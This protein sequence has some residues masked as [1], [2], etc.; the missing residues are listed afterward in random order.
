MKGFVPTPPAI[1]D[2]MV[3]K[4]FA[5]GPPSPNATLLDP[6]CG[7]GAFIE[8]VIR[9]CES[10]GLPLPKIT[11][12]DSNPDHIEVARKVFGGYPRI[13][14]REEDFLAVHSQQYDYIIGNPPY[15]PITSLSLAE[16][17]AYRRK[18]RTASGRFDLYLLFF[19]QCLAS[20]NPGGRLVLI[21]PEKFLYVETASPLREMLSDVQVEEFH[22]ADEDTFENLITYPLISTLVLERST[23]PTRIVHRDGS[24]SSVFLSSRA[25]SWLPAI[26]GVESSPAAFQLS[27]IAERVSCGV[28]TGADSVFI[29]PSSEIPYTLRR[30]A[31]PTLAG[32]DITP[33]RILE[34]THSM[35][36]PYDRRG[37]LLD[38]SELGALG[39]YLTEPERRRKLLDRT[40]VARK[41]WY[42]FHENPPLPDIL[43]P[44]IL[45]KDIGETPY[46]VA[47][48][49]GVIPRH[50]IYYIIPSD[51][52]LVEP[53]TAYLNSLGV[54][55]WLQGH[56]QRAA[57]GFLRLQSHVL[58]R[59][60]VP[61]EFVSS[62][63]PLSV[64]S[65]K[66][67]QL[68]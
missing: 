21:T 8:G 6:G 44:K 67:P 12:V 59:L 33:G 17:D 2:A 47:D 18:F 50:S 13:R 15:V 22:F 51:P 1:V 30:F 11:G 55:E 5:G 34:S 10:R 56:C 49:E 32:R 25:K 66:E 16:K 57:Q 54:S 27:D 38:E 63:L 68:V 45:C 29:L 40:C 62:L 35:L 61:A 41:P 4:L 58:K 3:E 52:H 7:T 42:A 14:I 48:T 53:L 43:R 20:L 9:W 37:R 36:V 60:P 26:R 64:P 46:F 39:V 23:A 31:Y 65:D 19:E 28:A 24:Q